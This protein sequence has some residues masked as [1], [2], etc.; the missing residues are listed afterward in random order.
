MYKEVSILC[1]MKEDGGENRRADK[2]K[3]SKEV[4]NLN[5]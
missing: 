2:R 1:E 3:S 5:R 4:Q